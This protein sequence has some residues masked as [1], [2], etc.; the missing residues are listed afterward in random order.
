MGNR[1]QRW[2]WKSKGKFEVVGGR[3]LAVRMPLPLV[4]VWEELQVEAERL[5]GQANPPYHRASVGYPVN[6][7][8]GPPA[9]PAADLNDGGRRYF[10]ETGFAR[11]QATARVR[12]AVRES[13]CSA[14]SR[15]VGTHWISGWCQ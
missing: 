15:E 3:E 11:M 4:E 2:G 1:Y 8:G 9:G 14:T 6:L 10:V 13:V 7:M 5:T 12:L